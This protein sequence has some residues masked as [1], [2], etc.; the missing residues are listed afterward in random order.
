[1]GYVNRQLMKFV[2][3]DVGLAIS[4]DFMSPDPIPNPT[5]LSSKG[6]FQ[7]LKTKSTGIMGYLFA[8]HSRKS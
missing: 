2:T 6:T 4:A 3:D 5:R 7:K 1:M 8:V